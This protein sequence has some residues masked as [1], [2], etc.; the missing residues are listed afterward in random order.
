MAALAG[1]CTAA[2]VGQAEFLGQAL[3]GGASVSS[4]NGGGA[5]MMPGLLQVVSV[6]GTKKKLAAGPVKKAVQKAV[7]KVNRPTN[8]ELAKWYGP[9][10]RIYLP[11]GLLSKSDIP[12]YLTGEVPGD[13]GFDPFG[14]SKKPSDFDKYQAYELIHGRWAMLGAA[15]FVLPEAFNRSGAV[16][17]PE[18]V[19]FKTGALLLDGN[20][21]SYFGA[22]IP[23]NLAAAVIAEVLLVGGA[24]YYRSTNKSPLGSDLDT[25]HPG[26]AFD[27]LGLAKDPDQ[28]ALLKVKEIK[29]GRLA[30]FSM[31]GF[32]IQAYVTGQGPVE[33]LAAHLSDPFGNNL[34]TVLQGTA[35]RVPSL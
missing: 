14:L 2:V 35:E 8:E 21:L 28:F 12:A 16:C 30:M 13:Y 22:S 25:L 26:G 1:R 17:G 27:P 29:N 32:F 19:W 4:S 33:N 7:A 24:E 6:L 3:S 11:E 20:T 31:L 18:A 23:V 10:R 34:L 15:G 9:D 5:V